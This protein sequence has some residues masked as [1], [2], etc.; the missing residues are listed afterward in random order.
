MSQTKAQLINAVDGSIVDADIVGLTSSKLS[1]ALPALSAANLTSIPAANLTGALPAISGASLTNLPAGGKIL[2]VVQD[3]RTSQV[4][5]SSHSTFNS[6]SGLNVDIT[7]SAATSKVLVMV[8]M[9]HAFTSSSMF[10]YKLRRDS[11]FLLPTTGSVTISG[12]DY[13]GTFAGKSNGTRGTP[14]N[15]NF[16]DE[17][18]T[19]S[20]INYN[21]QIMHNSGTYS[22]NQRD[23]NYAG[24]STIIAIEVG[25]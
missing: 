16:L 3:T 14:A 10:I 5:F 23:G 18:S 9:T 21:L 24:S 22:L 7:P 19:T 13:E 11:T 1:G 20:Q 2:Q 15:F 12:V 17:P 25:A 8:S 4:S 6:I